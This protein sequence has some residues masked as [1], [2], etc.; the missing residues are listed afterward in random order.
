MPVERK[1]NN[2]L[3]VMTLPVKTVSAYLCL[4]VRQPGE[5]DRSFISNTMLYEVS[6]GLQLFW[7]LS[8]SLISQFFVPTMKLAGVTGGRFLQKI[9]TI[10][11]QSKTR[12][13]QRFYCRLIDSLNSLLVATIRQHKNDDFE[14]PRLIYYRK[15]TLYRFIIKV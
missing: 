7:A 2:G 13:E 15:I 3:Q 10:K 6:S 11:A 12:N 14:Q 4:N 5:C 8:F 9:L 1:K